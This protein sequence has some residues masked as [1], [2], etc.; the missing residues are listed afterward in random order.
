MIWVLHLKHSVL[1]NI[2]PTV[3]IPLWWWWQFGWWI[4]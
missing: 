2:L 3:Q 4:S 1:K